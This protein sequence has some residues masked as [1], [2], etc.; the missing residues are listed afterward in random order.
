[1][2]TFTDKTLIPVG[3]ALAII[4]GGTGWLTSLAAKAAE[5][6]RNQITILSIYQ[7][8]QKDMVEIKIKVTEISEHLKQLDGKK[9]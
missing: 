2:Q 1:M 3:L 5:I 6:D 4:G 7:D 9:R 8:I